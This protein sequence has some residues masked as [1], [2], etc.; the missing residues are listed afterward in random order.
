MVDTGVAV[1]GISGY[2]FIGTTDPAEGGRGK[3]VEKAK[4]EV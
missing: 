1:G 4:L 3:E 2:Q